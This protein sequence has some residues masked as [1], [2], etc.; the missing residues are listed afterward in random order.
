MIRRASYLIVIMALTSALH[1]QQTAVTAPREHDIYCAGI[2]TTTPPPSGSYVVSGVESGTR[3]TFS[4]GD[5]VYINRGSAQGTQVGSEFLVSRRVKD[6]LAQSWFVWQ[7][8]LMKAMGS[9]YAD[10]GRIRV[11]HVET[12][13]STWSK[14]ESGGR[15]H[16]SFRLP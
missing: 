5:L 12:N 13:T 14:S 11:V 8:S 15:D 10:I 6:P 3:I 7:D 9:T 4:R 2:V 16:E 1:A